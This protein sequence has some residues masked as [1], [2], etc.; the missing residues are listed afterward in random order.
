MRLAYVYGGRFLG[1][2]SSRNVTTPS[3]HCRCAA[4]Q[5]VHLNLL[6]HYKSL[7][8]LTIS[9]GI[10]VASGNPMKLRK[11]ATPANTIWN[12]ILKSLGSLWTMEDAN[13]VD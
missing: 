8:L 2:N 11:I 9:N 5:L 3:T 10:F 7:F 6:G 13:D 12:R 4:G 1:E